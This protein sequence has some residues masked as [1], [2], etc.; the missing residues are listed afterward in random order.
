[1]DIRDPNTGRFQP[2]TSPGPA[3]PRRRRRALPPLGVGFALANLEN[4][5]SLSASI[6]D[7]TKTVLL[8]QLRQLQTAIEQ[9]TAERSPT[10]PPLGPP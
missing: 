10:S 3:R 4:E 6:A 7:T 9:Q 5:I 8:L 2:G 1:M